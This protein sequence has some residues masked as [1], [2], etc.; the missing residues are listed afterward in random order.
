MDG[1]DAHDVFV[2]KRQGVVKVDW[3]PIAAIA[4]PAQDR[5][6]HKWNVEGLQR[7]GLDKDKIEAALKNG[8]DG[9]VVWATSSS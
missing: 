1:Q 3:V 6:L 9:G 5:I 7:L 8:A 4:I 2:A